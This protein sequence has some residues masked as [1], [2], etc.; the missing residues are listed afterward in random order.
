MNKVY[1]PT[2]FLVEDAN[3][4]HPLDTKSLLLKRRVIWLD[5][6][7][8]DETVDEVI[9]QLV[10]LSLE[11]DEPV[12]LLVDSPGGSIKAGMKLLEVFRAAPCV[13]RTVALGHAASMA[14][15]ILA[16]GTPG[17]RV[18]TPSGRVMIHEPQLRG[19]LSAST[20]EI[21]KLAEEMREEREAANRLL[22]EFTG[23]ELEKVREAASYD[24]WFNADDAV[25]F[26]L[27]DHVVE[28]KT[29]F[30]YISGGKENV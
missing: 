11:S 9:R 19:G 18:I 15:L 4:I 10:L 26:G 12:T 8:E 13:I 5:G 3:G 14:A 25:A 1:C 17:H 7:I 24:H 27:A 28:G 22:S 16:G 21:E 2:P 30:Q 29:L 6:Q 20:T 23:Q